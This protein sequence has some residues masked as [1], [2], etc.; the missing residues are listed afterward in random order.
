MKDASDISARYHAVWSQACED[1]YPRLLSLSR[2]LT[3]NTDA[4]PDI[5]HDA[6]CKILKLIP[7]PTIIEDKVNYLLKSV[8]NAWLDRLKE[9]NKVK[10]V[11][12]D[13]PDNDELRSQLIAQERDVMIE[14]DNETYRNLLRIELR[15]LNERERLLLKLFLYGF[16]CEEIAARLEA[17]APLIS[18]ELN[19]VRNKVRQRLIK[20]IERTK[21]PGQR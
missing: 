16:S 18:Y 9:N 2:W 13:D 6:V 19:A 17:N 7:D 4:A 21:G 11:S 5:V 20:I 8:R 3:K 15:R 10:S 12:L 14:L 1:S